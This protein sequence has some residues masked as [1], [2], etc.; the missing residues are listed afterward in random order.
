[1]N[2]SSLFKICAAALCLSSGASHAAGILPETSVVV[3]E[4]GEGESAI[5]VTNTDD[6]PVL[7]LTTLENIKGDD[8]TLLA[9]TPPATRVEPGKTQRVRFIMTT[10]KPLATERLK[11]VIFEGVPPAS[12]G[13]TSQLRMTVRQNLPL[14]IRPAGLEKDHA[15]WKRLTWQQQ[16]NSLTVSNPSAYVV[17]LAQAVQTLPDNTLWTLPDSFILP[18][19]KLTLTPDKGKTAGQAS[20]VRISPATTWGYSV[21]IY[22]AELKR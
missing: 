7:M 10:D 11:R 16:G 12:K 20:K 22:D 21:D 3:V 4:Q 17:R 8:E 1:M 15:P 13:N 19:Q 6:F 2:V 18:G 9:I 5:N 14:I